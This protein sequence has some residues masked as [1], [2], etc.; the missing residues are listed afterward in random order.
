LDPNYIASKLSLLPQFEVVSIGHR[1]EKHG[2]VALLSGYFSSPVG[3]EEQGANLFLSDM[4]FLDGLLLPAKAD[5]SLRVIEAGGYS[6]SDIYERDVVGKRLAFFSNYDRRRLNL[7]LNPEIVWEPV[8]FHPRKAIQS[9][10]IGTDGKSRC[11]LTEYKEGA[12]LQ[13]DEMIVEAAWD[14]EHCIFCWNK[15]DSENLG[16]TSQHK[17]WGDEWACE[18]CYKNSVAPHDPCPLLIPYAARV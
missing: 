18:W 15:I 4:R 17:E 14:H 3:E 6:W 16:Y 8:E 1:T 2:R 5:E 9:Y 10:V 13:A 12:Q 7:V 11:R